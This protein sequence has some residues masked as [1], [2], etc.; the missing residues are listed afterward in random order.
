MK[1]Q[2]LTQ[3]TYNSGFKSQE[4]SIIKGKIIFVS[5]DYLREIYNFNFQYLNENGEVINTNSSNFS[6]TKEEIDTF[7]DLIKLEVPT[8]LA[9]FETTE[10]IYYLGFKVRMADTFGINANQ[11]E[12]IN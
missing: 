11:I 3:V 1:I 2:T 4:T 6:L 9:Y 8:D 10:Y 5:Q 12:I 7:Y